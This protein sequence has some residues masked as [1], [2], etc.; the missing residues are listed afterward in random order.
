M[1]ASFKLRDIGPLRTK[2]RQIKEPKEEVIEDN[3]DKT[4]KDE[5][6]GTSTKRNVKE[7]GMRIQDE[8]REKKYT[9]PE[10]EPMID[11]IFQGGEQRR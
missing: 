9:N 4:R 6:Q 1:E 10:H 5:F 7:I 11:A 3:A 8:Y 2:L